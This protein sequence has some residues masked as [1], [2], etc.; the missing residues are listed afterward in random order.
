M[1]E[2]KQA[3]VIGHYPSTP[4]CIPGELLDL[5]DCETLLVPRG[6]T[7][8][9]ALRRLEPTFDRTVACVGGH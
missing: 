1:A 6:N 7:N 3:E 4:Y 2:W 5:L 8:E 9:S